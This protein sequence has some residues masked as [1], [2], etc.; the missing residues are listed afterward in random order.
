MAAADSMNHS[1][2]TRATLVL[3]VASS[4]MA[5][6]PSRALAQVQAKYLYPLSSF[7]GRLPYEWVR[8]IVDEDREETYVVNQNIVHVF[9]G[10]GMEVFS[11]GE[12][13]DLGLLL[14]LAVDR[15]GD[16]LLLSYKDSG[17][18]VTRCSFRGEPTGAVELTNLP[19]GVKFEP[20]RIIQRNGLLYFASLATG[21]V[22]VTDEDGRYREHLDLLSKLEG[23]ARQK[24]GAELGGFAV[25]HGGNIWF[26]VPVLFKVYKY[27]SDGAIVSF[28]RPGSAAGRFGVVAGVAVDRSGSVFVADKLRSVVMIFDQNFNLVTEIGRRG[29]R[30]ENLIIPSEVVY[31]GR[32]KIYVT[33]GYR[34][35][36]SVFSVEQK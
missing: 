2:L 13:L 20:S 1:R 16:I 25:D 19:A 18:A 8:V 10:S 29:T 15:R 34:R 31:D 11:F 35:G 30:P 3:V 36:V 4:V 9:N 17:A 23:E 7:G 6:F 26:T 5:G 22:V 12:D 32:G 14:D 24:E 33:Q 27:S 21:R 28:G